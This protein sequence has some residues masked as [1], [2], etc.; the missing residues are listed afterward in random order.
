MVS[1]VRHAHPAVPVVAI[2]G[3]TRERV[4]G[5]VRS[6]A[7]GVAVVRAWWKAA[8]AGTAVTGLLDAL[9]EAFEAA[10]VLEASR[11]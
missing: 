8:D 7:S 6:G 11:R 5:A 1:R 9:D 3:I 2:G 4:A 10:G